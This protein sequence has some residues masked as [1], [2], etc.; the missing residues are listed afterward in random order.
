MASPPRFWRSIKAVSTP[1]PTTPAGRLT[2]STPNFVESTRST[3]TATSQTGNPGKVEISSPQLTLS[4]NLVAL[5]LPGLSAEAYLPAQ[6]GKS[7]GGDVSSFIVLGHDGLPLEP[8]GWVTSFP[9]EQKDKGRQHP[10]SPE[11]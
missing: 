5:S 4:G 6:C 1:T 10:D 2:F 3:V 8:G 11:R 7:L 9:E